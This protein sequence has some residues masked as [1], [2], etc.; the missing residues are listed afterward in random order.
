MTFCRLRRTTVVAGV[1]VSRRKRRCPVR[2]QGALWGL[3]AVGFLWGCTQAPEERLLRARCGRCHSYEQV[4]AKRKS[5]AAWE[6]TVWSMRR[7]GAELT[8]AEAEQLV[9]YLSRVR[10]VP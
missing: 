4:L 5:E 7:R 9:R 10:G 8:D 1:F 2:L 3:F 6:R